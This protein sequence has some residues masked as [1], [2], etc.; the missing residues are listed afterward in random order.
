MMKLCIIPARGGSTRIP[1]KN[2]RDFCGRPIISY[3][4]ETA[5]KAGFDVIV[6]TDD[7][8]IAAVAHEWG[9]ATDLR[10]WE[11]SMDG[12]GTQEV[13]AYVL[14]KLNFDRK[15]IVAVVY[16]CAPLLLAEDLTLASKR[17]G[18]FVVAVGAHPL[19]DA[20]CM[21][22]GDCG[23]FLD[24]D[25]LYDQY[26]VLHVLPEER[27]CDINTEEDWKEA[28]FLYKRLTRADQ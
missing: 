22:V 20:G 2:I 11:M 21:Y 13:A 19:R 12:V 23:A 3:S 18:G 26:T 25:P 27:V 15:E 5:R 4:I 14:R 24:G 17:S 1:G 6:S 8:G 10:S 28:V 7:N 9:A 16:P